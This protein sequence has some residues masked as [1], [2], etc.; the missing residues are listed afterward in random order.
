VRNQRP[1]IWPSHLIVLDKNPPIAVVE[2][3]TT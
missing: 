1:D 3:S 2:K